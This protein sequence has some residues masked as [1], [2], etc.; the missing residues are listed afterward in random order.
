MKFYK[1]IDMR[2]W[3]KSI[4]K[5][6]KQH[7]NIESKIE[8]VKH[9]LDR[10][11]RMQVRPFLKLIDIHLSEHCNLNCYSCNHFAQLAKKEFYD[12]AKFETDMKQL[13]LITGG[14][15]ES[16]HCLG[17]EPL[18]NKN[19]K[20]YFTCI[21]QHF[22]YSNIHLLTN[23]ILLPKQD[24]M[25]WQSCRD[26]NVIIY[27]T[28]YPIVDWNLVQQLCDK[29]NVVL[30]FFNDT[31][32]EKESFKVSLNPK[33]DSPLF[34]TFK[35][36]WYAN[37]CTILKNGRIYPCPIA[38]NISHFNSYFKQNLAITESDYLNI[39]EEDMTYTK[40]LHFISKPIPFC[41]Y[42]NFKNISFQPW[43]QSKKD[44]YEY[45]EIESRDSK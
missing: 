44:I 30:R 34:D 41:R 17:G 43:L 38:G 31:S 28:K 39:Y 20:D 13:S 9:E 5:N 8:S 11:D 36:C 37:N 22:P 23:G 10:L 12:F 3:A 35:S 26:N 24:S 25:F 16:I 4:I 33:G 15:I 42:C 40:I 18:L 19:C 14:M 6:R 45:Y 21:R 32:V 29:N 7:I 27:G 2:E 1:R